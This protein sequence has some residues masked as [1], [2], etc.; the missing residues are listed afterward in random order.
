MR[1]VPHINV[2]G[3]LEL[4]MTGENEMKKKLLS[5]ALALVMCL[6]LAVPALANSTSTANSPATVSA[7]GY[8]TGLI[9]KNGS[10]W[11]WGLYKPIG[12]GLSKRAFVPA[13]VLDN[14]VSISCGTSHTAA[15]KTDGSLWMWGSNNCGELGNG[16]VGNIHDS[17]G[18]IYQDVPVKVM[19]KVAAVSCGADFTAAIKTDGSLWM[20]GVNNDMQLGNNGVGNVHNEDYGTYQNIPVKVMDNVAAV[21]CGS[22]HVA[23]IKTDGSMWWWGYL[24]VVSDSESVSE[25]YYAEPV[26]VMDNVVAVSCGGS[27][28]AAIKTDGSLWMSGGDNGWGQLGDSS[29]IEGRSPADPVKVLDNVATVSCGGSHTAAVK[30][31]GSLL[32]WGNNESGQLGS[33]SGNTSVPFQIPDGKG[34]ALNGSFP[35]QTVPS[36]L[37]DGVA[38]ISGGNAYTIIVKTDGSVWAC[39]ANDVGQLGND[40]KHNS[41]STDGRAMQTTPV[42]LSGLTARAKL[43]T[44]FYDIAANA[45][46]TDAVIWAMGKGITSGT[47]ATTF[48]PDKVCTT[49]EILTFLWKAQNSPEPA[50]SNPF[51]DVAQSSYY[52]KAALW[53][54]EKGLV[55]G[56]VF[57]ANV[58]GTRGMTVAYLWKLAGKPAAGASSFSDVSGN[59]D[60]AQAVAWAV[61]KGI[62]SGT[63][64][65]TFSP[66]TIC[67]RGQIMTFLYRDFAG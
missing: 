41:V 6:G 11:M 4:K 51:S 29:S 48:S 65:N 1:K 35:I 38:T 37:M 24:G 52:Y 20:F 39:G 63:G 49:G 50:I 56:S 45:Y 30:T 21:S 67:T 62:T 10:L 46:Y 27:H 33:S 64:N 5:L 9:D 44:A 16:G 7:G 2:C 60:Y 66:N 19:D 15:I 59:A 13:K 57:E 26:K 36:K 55:S 8:H 58:P 28:T 42:K 34:G 53:A 17:D 3:I 14:V 12:N 23:A 47:S 22:G 25:V 31:D 54:Y 18:G 32:V 40:G 43:P 61:S